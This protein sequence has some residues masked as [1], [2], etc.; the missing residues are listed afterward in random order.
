[1]FTE[2]DL[3]E[4][5]ARGGTA[6]LHRLSDGRVLKV[7]EDW[8]PEALVRNEALGARIASELGLPTPACGGV[9][10]VGDRFAIPMTEVRGGMLAEH[11]FANP[12]DT[13]GDAARVAAIHARLAACT[14]PDLRVGHG[15]NRSL[16]ERSDLEP[17]ARAR[18]LARFDELATGDVLCHGD[19]HAGN[20]LRTA[21]GDLVVIDWGAAHAGSAAADA[22]QTI[23]A[24]SEWLAM[25]IDPAWKVV[26]ERFLAA[27]RTAR[28]DVGA[29]IDAW[30]P[31]VAALR[32]ASPHPATSEG[33]LRD[34]V[35]LA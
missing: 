28:T 29:D 21:D 18:V 30:T 22:T 3:E 14:H 15:F 32:L 25:P 34:L 31:V 9:E 17:A 20:V 33:P 8:V 16:L 11:L 13:E 19:F 6:S 2:A 7:F 10:R 23:V 35:A 4:P 1:V 27:Y 5:F 26:V 12:D 24:M